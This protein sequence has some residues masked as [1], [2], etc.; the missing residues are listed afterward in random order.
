V[1]VGRRIRTPEGEGVVLHVDKCETTEHDALGRSARLVGFMGLVEL[2]DGC[3]TVVSLTGCPVKSIERLKE[4]ATIAPNAGLN[5]ESAA[6]LRALAASCARWRRRS[7][8][9]HARDLRERI[10]HATNL[11]HRDAEV[12]ESRSKLRREQD[13]RAELRIE[14]NRVKADLAQARRD[15]CRASESLEYAGG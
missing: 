2:D 12:I 7:S 6:E 1:I 11:D 10:L 15:L 3:L 9:R 14:L 5:A 8:T 4:L 13:A